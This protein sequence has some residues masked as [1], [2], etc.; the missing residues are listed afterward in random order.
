M[1]ENKLLPEKALTPEQEARKKRYLLNLENVQNGKPEDFYPPEMKKREWVEITDERELNEARKQLGFV[2]KEVPAEIYGL[3]VD[4]SGEHTYFAPRFNKF[5]KMRVILLDILATAKDI[6]PWAQQKGLAWFSDAE[7]W[8][9]Q[10]GQWTFRGQLVACEP[11]VIENVVNGLGDSKYSPEQRQV[12]L[13]EDVS[14]LVHENVH[15]NNNESLDFGGP[16]RTIRETAP[17]AAE[18]LAFPGKNNKIKNVFEGARKLLRGEQEKDDY[19][20]DA[21]LLGMLVMAQDEGLLPEDENIDQIETRLDEWQV[22]IEN[23]SGDDLT[24]YRRKVEVEW[25]LSSNDE[26]LR[27]KLLQLKQKY[28]SLIHRLLGDNI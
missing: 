24:A 13:R 4:E 20:N 2:A 9:G 5:P 12:F 18:Y 7:R 21:T 10:C 14:A 27:A 8:N 6:A 28:P 17:M 11:A 23:L 1:R 22:Q 26:K 3:Y 25:L 19:Y 15:L 16:A